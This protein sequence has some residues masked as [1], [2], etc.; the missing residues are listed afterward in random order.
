V[1]LY[2]KHQEVVYGLERVWIVGGDADLSALA[3]GPEGVSDGIVL[4]FHGRDAGRHFVVDEHGNVEVV[5]AEHS[6]DM[7]QVHPYLIAGCVVVLGFGI[8]F[9]DSAIGEERE[10]VGGGLV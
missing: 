6:G 2:L 3:G 8:D 5:S 4:V 10:V 7:G 9:D 1:V